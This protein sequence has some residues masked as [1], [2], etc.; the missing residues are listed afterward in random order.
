MLW[1]N[2]GAHYLMLQGISLLLNLEDYA[3]HKASTLLRSDT[4]YF[5]LSHNIHIHCPDMH[6]HNLSSLVGREIACILMSDSWIIPKITV[7]VI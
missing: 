4:F 7:S 6:I 2:N 3:H 1:F 5:I